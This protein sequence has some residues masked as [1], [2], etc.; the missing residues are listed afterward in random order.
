LIAQAETE[1]DADAHGDLGVS[2]D[3]VVDGKYRILPGSPLIE[4]NRPGAPG[5]VARD[6]RNPG[7]RLFANVCDPGVLPRVDT[8]VQ[9]KTLREASVIRPV[10]WD[11]VPWPQA[12]QRCFAIVYEHPEEA[13]IMKSLSD[14]VHAHSTEFL[15]SSVLGPLSMTLALM[16]RRGQVHRAISPDNMYRMGDAG[17]SVLLGDCV[18]S[19]PGWA[20]RALMETI[21]VG[22]TPRASR[23]P[24]GFS[25]DIYALGASMLFLALGWCPVVD[26]D[27]DDVI[28]IKTWQGS[29]MALLNGERPSVGLRE[30][31]RGMLNDD[32]AERW[33]LDDIE[34]WIGGVLRRSV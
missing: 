34:Q 14:R 13:P 9:L 31:L 3:I 28:E 12:R 8:L 15:V 20:Q 26:L 4:L 33:T 7:R 10:A 27:D 23:G 21:E 19:P 18:T 5:Y 2:S 17:E 11:P 22:M 6:Q 16:S 25:D 32:P 1:A 29:F 24:G 30:P